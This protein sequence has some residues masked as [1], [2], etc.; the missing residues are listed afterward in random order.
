MGRIW[1]AAGRSPDLLAQLLNEARLV[2]STRTHGNLARA[3]GVSHTPV[4]SSI[5]HSSKRVGAAQVLIEGCLLDKHRV[6]CTCSGIVPS[7]KKEGILTLATAWVKLK[8]G[9]LRR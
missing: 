9:M 6:A 1:V 3:R 7:L 4:H 5:V 8:D 2:A